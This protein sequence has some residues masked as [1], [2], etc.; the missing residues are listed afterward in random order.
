MTDIRLQTERLDLLPLPAAAAGALLE[1]RE[2]A[3]RLL[4]GTLSPSW[5]HDDLLDVLPLQAAAGPDE[6]R[7]GIWTLIERET[8]T[9]VGDIGFRGPPGADGTVEIGYCV[10][11]DRR[12]RGFATEAARALIE[13]VL[14]QPGVH[15]VVAGCDRDNVAS[16]R[17]LERL[18]FSRTGEANSELRWRWNAAASTE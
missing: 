13:W 17:T 11:P 8:G 5:P 6:E 7:F 12:R 16:I 2:T 3:A 15:A 14:R 10:I 18:G 9:V 4:G 1:D